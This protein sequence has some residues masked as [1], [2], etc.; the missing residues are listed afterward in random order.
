M[1]LLASLESYAAAGVVLLVVIFI[2][3]AMLIIA[4]TVGPKRHGP[5]KDGVYESGVPAIG[6]ARRRFG[7]KFYMVAVLFLLF[8]VEVIFM[9]PW[10]TAFH[11][12]AVEGTTIPLEASD[13]VGKGFLLFGMGLF[14]V[15]LV[16]GLAYEW[17]KGALKWD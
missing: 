4:H 13:P 16:F 1:Q 12:A 5:T 14:F 6:D 8:D 11:K 3:V 15:L 7:L 9:W 17:K 2:A 10:A